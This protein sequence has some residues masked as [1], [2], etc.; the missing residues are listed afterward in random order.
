MEA[1]RSVTAG[2]GAASTRSRPVTAGH[3]AEDSVTAVTGPLALATLESLVHERLACATGVRS[4]CA[5]R[6]ATSAPL[7]ASSCHAAIGSRIVPWRQPGDWAVSPPPRSSAPIPTEYQA[8]KS[9]SKASTMPSKQVKCEATK[10]LSSKQSCSKSTQ[11]SVYTPLQ[12][13]K[14]N[15]QS[16]TVRAAATV[17]Q[18]SHHA[19]DSGSKEARRVLH[20]ASIS[21]IE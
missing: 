12:T 5:A 8:S 16:Q 2:H 17:E 10:L 4:L 19:S 6:A 14:S 21:N 7:P 1:R 9:A 3:V 13:I 15:Q 11:V 20:L 18:A